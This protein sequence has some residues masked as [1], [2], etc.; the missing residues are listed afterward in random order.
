MFSQGGFAANQINRCALLGSGLGQKQSTIGKVEGGLPVLARDLRA[1]RLPVKPAGNHQMNNEK[2][3]IFQIEDDA[4]T[5]PAQ[6]QDCF[7]F[8]RADAR[9]E[10]ANDKRA[11]DAD[12]LNRLIEDTLAQCFDVNGYVRELRHYLPSQ[13]LALQSFQPF[14]SF[15]ASIL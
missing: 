1:F 15:K 4:F 3:S 14:Q 2:E 8:R 12:S 10:R 13:T 9:V 7:P 5:D 6:G 11:A